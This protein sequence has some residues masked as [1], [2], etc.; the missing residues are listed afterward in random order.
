MEGRPATR[1]K[2]KTNG[3]TQLDRYVEASP[4]E[5]V[6]ETRKRLSDRSWSSRNGGSGLDLRGNHVR[7]GE[8]DRKKQ[9]QVACQEQEGRQHGSPVSTQGVGLRKE[10]K[11]QE[12]QYPPACEKF[13]P[14]RRKERLDGRNWCRCRVFPWFSSHMPMRPPSY[15]LVRGTLGNFPLLSPS[16]SA[17][18]R[19][20][21]PSTR[22]DSRCSL[23]SLE[24]SSFRQGLRLF[25]ARD[26]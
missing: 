24:Y 1:L 26:D 21:A 11:T 3:E 4:P 9:R 5:K 2:K 20:H 7:C 23:E 10:G 17:R 16:L 25:H 6:R 12:H 14:E 8:N 22:L 19:R 15:G 13:A 18:T